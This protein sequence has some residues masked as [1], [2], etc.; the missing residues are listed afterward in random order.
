VGIRA[1]FFL[2]SPCR[3]RSASGFRERRVADNRVLRPEL[4]LDQGFK[5]F[6]HRCSPIFKNVSSCAGPHDRASLGTLTGAQTSFASGGFF[7]KIGKRR[8]SIPVRTLRSCSQ[9]D[10]P[11]TGRLVAF[12]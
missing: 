6:R 12:Q 9:R 2:F 10:R 11:I 5:V 4:S 1:S 7:V 8:F 3:S